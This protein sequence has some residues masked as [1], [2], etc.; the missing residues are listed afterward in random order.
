M[1]ISL[2]KET[3]CL[4]L[5]LSLHLFVLNG[6]YAK[7]AYFETV[8]SATCHTIKYSINISTFYYF[9]V[10]YMQNIYV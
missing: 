1:E 10:D 9:L 3:V 5:E 2:L 7:E 6:P 8:Y 4:L